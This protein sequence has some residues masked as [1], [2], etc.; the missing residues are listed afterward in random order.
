L[1][2]TKTGANQDKE[3]NSRRDKITDMKEQKS[4]KQII[5]TCTKQW[6]STK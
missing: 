5:C 4:V 6:N 1:K 2:N 3:L